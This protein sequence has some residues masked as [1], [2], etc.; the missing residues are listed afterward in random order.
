MTSF[1]EL[2]WY[3]QGVSSW[4]GVTRN[5]EDRIK[6]T[7]KEEQ[8]IGDTGITLTTIPETEGRLDTFLCSGEKN[9]RSNPETPD[10]VTNFSVALNSYPSIKGTVMLREFLNHP[11][12]ISTKVRCVTVSLVFNFICVKNLEEI[13]GE[14]Y[15]NVLITCVM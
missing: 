12:I 3:R 11:K 6:V 2:T 15:I 5:I 7:S 10:K 9:L 14:G 13:K 4:K 8:V 1:K